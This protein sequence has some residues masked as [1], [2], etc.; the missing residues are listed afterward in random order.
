ML[1]NYLLLAVRVL[2]RRKFY[3]FVSLFGIAFTL[4]ILLVVTALVDHVVSASPPESRMGRILV[5][6]RAKMS[7]PTWTSSGSPGYGLLDRYARDLPGVERFA[8]A[9]EL[10]H[11]ISYVDDVRVL[12]RFKRADPAYWEIFDFN[13]V[14]GGPYTDEDAREGRFVAVI[15]ATT[16][17][18]FFNAGPALG[19]SIRLDDQ[20]FL[21]VGVVSDVS[22][23][24]ENSFA[25]AWAPI[26]TIKSTTYRSALRSGFN[27]ILLVENR[28]AFP[29]I[30]AEFLRR[31][32]NAE[33][34]DP[35]R[36][37]KLESWA[38]T[39]AESIAREMTDSYDSADP[40]LAQLF[41]WIALGAL[42]F[43]ALPAINLVNLNLSRI[44]ERSSEIGVRKAFGASSLTLVAQFVVE[45]VV[46]SL[47]GGL[48]GFVLAG[49]C[50]SLLN[51]SE[52]IPYADFT[53][54]LRVFAA[55]LLLSAFF[56]VLSGV[57]PAWRMSRLHPV[58]S[59]QGRAS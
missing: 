21:V 29:V 41:G 19:Q 5:I 28:D 2:L 43:M 49:G 34:T 25:E 35:V 38:D 13:F 42:L 37:D 32:A 30:K 55:G 20:S 40:A 53:L 47:I 44:L 39:T 50:L 59:I 36:F 31:I 51:R 10:D 8:I 26:E 3:T 6:S 15:N 12:T 52:L 1:R 45:S 57:Y 23:T 22:P 48:V 46:L 27:G 14:E 16:R 58:A 17:R 56:G 7:G 24:R 4:T 54:N 18:R 33:L 9:S 11:A